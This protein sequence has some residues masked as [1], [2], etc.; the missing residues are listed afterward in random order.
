MVRVV[1]AGPVEAEVAAAALP[2]RKEPVVAVE[3]QAR[4]QEQ[5]LAMAEFGAEL[6]VAFEVGLVPALGALGA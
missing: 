2:A 1:A 3:P 4:E 5:A 6:V